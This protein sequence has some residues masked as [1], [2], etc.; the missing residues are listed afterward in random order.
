MNKQTNGYIELN[1]Y[2]LIYH[3]TKREY[4]QINI[5]E[6]TIRKMFQQWWGFYRI[7]LSNFNSLNK[8]AI[9][10]ESV[11]PLDV[12]LRSLIIWEQKIKNLKYC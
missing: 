6:Y 4:F 5:Q 10:L 1:V 8:Q 7:T 11:M 9:C 3:P 12:K 2:Q